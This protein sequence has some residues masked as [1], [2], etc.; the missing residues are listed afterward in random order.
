MGGVS[1]GVLHASICPIGE[2]PELS[3]TRIEAAIRTASRVVARPFEMV[4]DRVRTY[5]PGP[6][7]GQKKRPLVL[8]AGNGAVGA[9]LL[10]RSLIRDLRRS[11]F[12]PHRN[13]P[14]FHMTLL[15]DRC[16]VAEEPI[17]PIRWMVRDFALVHS[18]HGEGRHVILG[19]WPL[20][21]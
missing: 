10:R 12:L 14:D 13:Q 1:P 2:F 18:I 6:A 4:L 17:A 8:F 15:Y 20:A 9:A 11:G 5:P 7:N 21:G 19:Q 16:V 3:E